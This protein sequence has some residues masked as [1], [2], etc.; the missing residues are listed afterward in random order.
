MEF[1]IVN[2]MIPVGGIAEHLHADN[3]FASTR[4]FCPGKDGAPV[5]L[6]PALPQYHV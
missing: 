2:L 5:H 1:F 4:N 3:L 6:P